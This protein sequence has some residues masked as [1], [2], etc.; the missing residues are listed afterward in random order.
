M[1]NKKCNLNTLRTVIFRMNLPS[2]NKQI[3]IFKEKIFQEILMLSLQM[4]RYN[5]LLPHKGAMALLFKKY[6]NASQIF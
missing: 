4:R 3:K 2:L 6:N 5:S 1:Q